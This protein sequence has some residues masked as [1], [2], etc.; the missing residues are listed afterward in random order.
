MI[1]WTRWLRRTLW[2]LGA[3]GSLGL[4]GP[5]VLFTTLR[6]IL[7]LF[8]VIDVTLDQKAVGGSL[9]SMSFLQVGD[10]LNI[11]SV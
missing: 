11:K 8:V 6:V 4:M 7:G 1:R 2:I 10:T 3:I 5:I 9:W